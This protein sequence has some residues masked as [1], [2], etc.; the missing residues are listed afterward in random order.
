VDACG[1]ASVTVAQKKAEPKGVTV[2]Q[3]STGALKDG[4]TTSLIT[5]ADTGT[6]VGCCPPNN[7]NVN[8]TISQARKSS[9]TSVP[10][11]RN[12]AANAIGSVMKENILSAAAASRKRARE[13]AD[14]SNQK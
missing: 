10:S 12:A 3:Y 11:T 2:Q 1:T 4:S 6:D 13:P 5:P 14:T 9:R 8:V 7:V